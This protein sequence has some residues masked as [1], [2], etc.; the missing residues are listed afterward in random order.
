MTSSEGWQRLGRRRSFS[1]GRKRSLKVA[2]NA[3]GPDARR[4]NTPRSDETNDGSRPKL[5]VGDLLSDW[6]QYFVGRRSLNPS[7]RTEFGARR[8]SERASHTGEVGPLEIRSGAPPRAASSGPSSPE[9]T[10]ARVREL[11][12]A[13]LVSSEARTESAIRQ[14]T[15]W[16]KCKLAAFCVER[17]RSHESERRI[18]PCRAVRLCLKLGVHASSSQS[19]CPTRWSR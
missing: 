2:P 8:R 10:A 19:G 18:L 17:D 5:A 4:C 13:E 7:R 15:A 11:V 14:I 6:P 12:R 3:A 1:S 9:N 16:A